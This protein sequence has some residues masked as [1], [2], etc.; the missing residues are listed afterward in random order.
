MRSS[1]YQQSGGSRG[2]STAK[3]VGAGAIIGGLIGGIAGGGK[4]AA[5]GAGVGGAGG[6]GVQAA[7][8]RGQVK[9]PS[10]SKIDFVLR[11]PITVTLAQ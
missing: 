10:E 2:E 11:A 8:K 3:K 5:I 4:G 7:S 9:V 6:G 1:L